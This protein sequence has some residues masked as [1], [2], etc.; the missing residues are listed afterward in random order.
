MRNFVKGITRYA[1]LTAVPLA[2]LVALLAYYS[3]DVIYWDEL[4]I[5]RLL[6][7]FY[8]HTLT[9]MDIFAQHNE[10]RIVLGKI[11]MLFNA[12]YFRWNIYLEIAV[13]VLFAAGTSIIVYCAMEKMDYLDSKKRM[14]LYFTSASLIFSFSQH[15]NFMWG[16]QMQI[17]M[18]VFFDIWAIY[19]LV[20]GGRYGLFGAILSGFIG[21]FSFANGM[22]VWPIGFMILCISAY[23][24]EGN[25][26]FWKLLTW[27]VVSVAGICL[28]FYGFRHESMQM[29]IPD[30]LIYLLTHPHMT[31][32]LFFSYLGLPLSNFRQSAALGLGILGLALQIFSIVKITLC[33]RW[34]RHVSMWLGVGMYALL[35]ATVTSFGRTQHISAT[36]AYRYISIAMTFW[37]AAIALF[38]L[39]A[40]FKN[41]QPVKF[42]LIFA[43]LIL[44]MS[45]S[46]D[47]LIKARTQS[48]YRTIFKEQLHDG[49]YDNEHFMKAAYPYRSAASLIPMLKKY[50]IRG[51]E[52]APEMISFNDFRTS[53]FRPESIDNDLGMSCAVNPPE[54]GHPY[55][56]VKH[57]DFYTI[58]GWWKI[59]SFLEADRK[60]ADTYLILCNDTSSFEAPL[61]PEGYNIRKELKATRYSDPYEISQ[62]KYF[63]GNQLYIGTLPSGIY[64]TFLKVTKDGHDY[65]A[66]L[67]TTVTVNN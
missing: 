39:A 17:F 18:S 60:V 67:N 45:V 2:V 54:T 63:I 22:V 36:M 62:R 11:I 12:V 13:N 65:Y 47:A 21:T 33:K 59:D 43:A 35:S 44:C 5:T 29:S 42:Y 53:N 30:K 31:L 20:Y 27:T 61:M 40:D 58:E 4:G 64:R 50:G 6:E 52:N 19:L 38:S 49:I 10:H 23:I 26:N 55:F 37:I 14:V 66:T 24:P 1:A 34:N 3:V 46:E 28:Y 41:E 9:F 48:E 57:K 15:Q 32:I 56:Y 16:F 25:F 8:N 7:K 51:Y